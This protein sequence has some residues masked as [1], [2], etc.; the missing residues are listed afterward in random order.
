MDCRINKLFIRLKAPY[1][2][3][4]IDTFKKVDILFISR[5]T[6]AKK[7]HVNKVAEKQQQ[8]KRKH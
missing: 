4:S 7:F 5:F 3:G 1:A 8:I 6:V 2:E